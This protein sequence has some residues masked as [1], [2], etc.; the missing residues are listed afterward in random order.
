MAVKRPKTLCRLRVVEWIDPR[1]AADWIGVSE[2]TLLRWEAK[3]LPHHGRGA[4]KAYP[5]PHALVWGRA[6]QIIAKTGLHGTPG[7]LVVDRL[8]FEYALHFD[9][10]LTAWC[11]LKGRIRVRTKSE[12]GS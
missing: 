2:R 7:P 12:I 3:G 11:I 4:E 6:Y 5:V 1:T 8:P 10:E 9:R